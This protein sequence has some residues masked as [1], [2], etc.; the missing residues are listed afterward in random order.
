MSAKTMMKSLLCR[1]RWGKLMKSSPNITSFAGL[2]FQG[3]L[4][5]P[6][7]MTIGNNIAI[8]KGFILHCFHTGKAAPQLV[9][10]DNFW[11]RD[12]L[13]VFCAEKVI[14]GKDVTLAKDIFISDENHGMNPM[15]DNYRKNPLETKEVV[16]GDGCWLGEKVCVL[17]GVHIGKKTI[18]G[19]G[20]VVTR[21]IPEYCIAVGNPCKVIKVWDKDQ[22][23]WV[24]FYGYS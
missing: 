12:N 6:Q 19:A 1:L 16:I 7:F 2:H 20:S 14:I 18:I 21:D 4:V 23:E 3:K 10:G 13:T 24:R 15:T 22:E 5:N 9:I 17:P 8:G 11:S